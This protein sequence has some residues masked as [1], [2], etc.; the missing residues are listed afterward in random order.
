MNKTNFRRKDVPCLCECGCGD[1][2]RPGEKY[3]KSHENK[4]KKWIIIYKKI[5][6]ILFLCLFVITGFWIGVEYTYKM[7]AIAI[8]GNRELSRLQKDFQEFQIDGEIRNKKIEIMA[9]EIM[10][11]RAINETLSVVMKNHFPEFATY[12]KTKTRKGEK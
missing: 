5:V 1:Y 4:A 7:E 8:F 12:R 6:Y 3:I 9:S 2:A 11:T 10:K